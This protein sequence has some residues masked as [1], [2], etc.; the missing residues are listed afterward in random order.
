MMHLEFSSDGTEVALSC[1]LRGAKPT[2]I[3]IRDSSTGKEL[4]LLES[5]CAL[6]HPRAVVFSPDGKNLAT[7]YDS[8]TLTISERATGRTVANLLGL[9]RSIRYPKEYWM[10][11]APASTRLFTNFG[12][13]GTLMC[14]D[15]TKDQVV[16]PVEAGPQIEAG[17][18]SAAGRWLATGDSYG[19]VRLW[20]LRS[21][22]TCRKYQAHRGPVRS[23]A[24]SADGR[25]LA[26]GGDDTAVL[27]WD[28]GP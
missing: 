2:G 23:L 16:E 13:E 10:A 25:W 7:L 15:W 1:P 24:L 22:K 8:Q 26:S 11:I 9:P 20:D 5:V 4:R 17:A 27:V 12:P 28:L 21:P 18:F 19:L 14:W 6:S 3:S